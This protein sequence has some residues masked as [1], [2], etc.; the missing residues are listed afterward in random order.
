[1]VADVVDLE[2]FRPVHGRQFQHPRVVESGFIF[3]VK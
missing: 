3:K 1:M 2:N